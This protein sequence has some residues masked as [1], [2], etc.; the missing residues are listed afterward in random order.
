VSVPRPR[1]VAVVGGGVGGLC[2]AIRLRAAGLEVDLFERNETFGGKV[3]VYARDGWSF[4]VGP[5]LVTWPEVLD[6]T[7]RAA[8]TSLA[9]EVRLERLGSPFR[10]FWPDATT[11][12]THDDP[13][14]TAS[15]FD[16][17]VPGAGDEYLHLL[18]RARRTWA[19]AER[20]FLAGPMSGAASLA[21][22]MRSPRDLV[23]IDAAR[24]LARLADA[25]FRDPRM[26]QWLGR[27]A[28]YSGS[29][30]WRA[31]ATL[32]CIV[33]L[34][35]D[36]GAWHPHGGLGA[37]RDALVTVARRAG[38]R[39]HPG[40]DVVRIAVRAGRATGVEFADGTSHAADAVVANADAAHVAT[41]LL[42][43]VRGAGRLRRR[44]R[45]AGRSTAGVAVVVGVR[46]TTPR[47]AHHNVWFSRDYRAEFDAIRAGRPPADPT[48]YACV[49]SRTDA[50]QAPSGCENWFL[51]ANVPAGAEVHDDPGRGFVA[52]MLEVVAEGGVELRDR[53]AFVDVLTP[54]HFADRY[55]A[56]GGAIYGTSSDG[57]RAAFLR[58]GNVGPVRGLWLVGGSSH[59]GGGLPLV[60]TSARI[61]ADL[62]VRGGASGAQ[63]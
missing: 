37:L 47:I 42:A 16:G 45:R 44:V 4:D 33:A 5:S 22:R 31:P 35:A 25:S 1:T 62:V 55:R 6:D 34:E 43:G 18:S 58:P 51:L 17:L 14:L 61:V 50:S 36:H 13:M 10:Y 12:A 56:P 24:T 52:R 57:R 60:A 54:R 40:A 59:P 11:L 26:R 27:Y 19:V 21:G 32:A 7:L 30:P 38:A 41:D 49:S 46:G 63:R 8:G 9:S 28:T 29:S 53:A 2:A 3:A 20:T 39:L 48:V 15:A 23:D